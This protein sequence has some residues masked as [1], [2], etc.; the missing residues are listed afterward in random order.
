[1]TGTWTSVDSV[2]NEGCVAAKGMAQQ[3]SMT[4]A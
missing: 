4:P 3:T 1:V 2:L